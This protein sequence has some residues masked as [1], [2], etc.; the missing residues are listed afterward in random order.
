MARKL[1]RFVADVDLYMENGYTARLHLTAPDL[2]F[3]KRMVRK[4]VY[5]KIG[6]HMESW[7]MDI[8]ESAYRK[9]KLRNKV[10]IAK[11]TKIAH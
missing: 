4:W 1:R 2:K 3:A 5:K 6:K 11:I 8:H 9:T 7:M 10:K